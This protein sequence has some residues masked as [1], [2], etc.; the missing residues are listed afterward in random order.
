MQNRA[1]RPLKRPGYPTRERQV[2]GIVGFVLLTLLLDRVEKWYGINPGAG[3]FYLVAV[4]FVACWSGIIPS[5]IDCAILV[6]YAWA[7]YN[8][9]FTATPSKPELANQAIISTAIF[10]PI[11]ALL[12][13]L[14][15]HYV[16][17]SAM[18]EWAAT[19]AANLASQERQQTQAE[20][21]ASE[22]I[23]RFIVNSSL[24]AI[25]GMHEDGRITMWNANAERLFGW[26]EAEALG[27]LI[28]DTALYL[29]IAGLVS[30]TNGEVLSKPVELAAR[31]KTGDPASIEV[32]LAKHLQGEETIYILFAR[33]IGER[34]Q[35]ELA[36]RNLNAS[37]E[38]RVAERTSQLE[39]ANNE[40][41][42]FTY[43][44]SH[45]LRAPL[46]A[47][48][49]NSRILGEDIGPSLEGDSVDRLRRLES[50]SLHLAQLIDNLLQFAR[51]GQVGLR[52]EDI[53]LSEM[54]GEVADH[55]KEQRPGEVSIEPGMHCEGDGELVRMVVENLMEN[56]WKYTAPDQ[57][58]RVEVG[59]TSSGDFYIRD[60]GIGF[61][62]RYEDKIWRPFERLHRTEDY[63]GTGIGLANCR[64]IIQ[65]HGGEIW[66]D[67]EVGKGSTF[68]FRF[69][70]GNELENSRV[71]SQPVPAQ[72]S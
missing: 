10:F 50:S 59:K 15:M 55:L 39:A 46:R 24:D 28:G 7:R 52:L 41:L 33:D 53:D 12:G 9:H 1:S 31:K 72:L 48:V 14:G 47:I 6:A 11:F 63:P 8:T 29:D 4:V 40:L 66:T 26:S 42:G 54:A 37:L 16:R 5:L 35:A 19:E 69:G 60:H 51:I 44:V 43:S 3:I 17:K 49:A 71:A 58:P 65:R 18:K 2:L 25:I 20:L 62:M 23:R 21:S 56:A 57:S 32:Y 27:K 34:K 68:Y 36:I 30:H 38:G 64:R 67:S 22:D 70:A 61:D 13:G 45:D